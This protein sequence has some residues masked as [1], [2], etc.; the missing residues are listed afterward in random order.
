MDGCSVTLYD[1]IPKNKITEGELVEL[2]VITM[3]GKDV[4]VYKGTETPFGL[5]SVEC[6]KVKFPY[7]KD[8]FSSVTDWTLTVKVDTSG[9]QVIEMLGQV[10]Q[11][12]FVKESSFLLKKKE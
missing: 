1:S 11:K 9:N 12:T 6:S 2:E 7:N 3:N 8:D 5:G 4:V 10:L